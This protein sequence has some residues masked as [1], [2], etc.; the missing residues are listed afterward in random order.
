MHITFSFQ[1]HLQGVEQRM[2][3]IE[4]LN[5]QA[6]EKAEKSAAL[7]RRLPELRVTVAER[8]HACEA[9]ET[10]PADDAEE[11]YRF[12][13]ETKH[14]EELARAQGDELTCLWAEVERLRK[15]N[16]PSMDQLKYN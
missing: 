4:R 2:K 9:L 1:T 11:R 7:E 13:V 3:R 8:T 16:F 15:R 12:I 10:N 5:R 6:A 14:L